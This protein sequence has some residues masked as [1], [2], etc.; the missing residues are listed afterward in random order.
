MKTRNGAG[1]KSQDVEGSRLREWLQV[2]GIARTVEVKG[3]AEHV[4]RVRG[5]REQQ[6]GGGKPE[7]IRHLDKYSSEGE[8]SLSTGTHCVTQTV[9]AKPNTGARTGGP[10][11]QERG[12]W[13]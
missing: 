9:G 10:Q 3:S 5:A 2:Y 4:A 8:G 1:Q 6:E 12:E 11:S 7:P 13:R